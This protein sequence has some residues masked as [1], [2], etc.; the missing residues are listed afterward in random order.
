VFSFFLALKA[1]YSP[2]FRKV[3]VPAKFRIASPRLVNFRVY[4]LQLIDLD[5][6]SRLEQDY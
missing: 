6:D 4:C 2:Y 5:K 1:P 3:P